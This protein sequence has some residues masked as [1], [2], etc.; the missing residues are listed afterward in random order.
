MYLQFKKRMLFLFKYPSEIAEVLLC[1][2]HFYDS[3]V[4]SA[5]VC[6]FFLA[7]K[8]CKTIN[9][10]MACILFDCLKVMEMVQ[11]S[12]P[13]PQNEREH[14]VFMLENIEISPSKLSERGNLTKPSVR[15]TQYNVYMWLVASFHTRS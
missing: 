3:L 8:C 9:V 15:L 12:R 5:G 13:L 11:S 4:I 14:M 1:T 2:L 10:V 6:V 7:S